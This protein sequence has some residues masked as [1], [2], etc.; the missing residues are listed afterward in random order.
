MSVSRYVLSSMG[1]EDTEMKVLSAGTH[2]EL[3]TVLSFKSGA[4]QSIA[5]HVSS[6]A[7]NVCLPEILATSLIF[8]SLP[9]QHFNNVHVTCIIAGSQTLTYDIMTDL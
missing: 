6:T 2:K 5:L 7:G 8:F 9:N 4:G 1:T 3:S